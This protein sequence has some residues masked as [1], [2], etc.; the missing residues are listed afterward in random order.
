VHAS[1]GDIAEAARLDLR[2]VVNPGSNMRLGNGAPP[3]AALMEAGIRFGLGTDNCALDDNED[4]LSELRLGRLLGRG[5]TAAAGDQLRSS[6]AVATEWGAEAAFLP[7]IGR[8]R[9]GFKADLVAIDLAGS[10]GAY[11]D[12]QMP[13]FE[14]MLAR[15]TRPRHRYDHGRRPHPASARRIGDGGSREHP[16]RGEPD[17]CRDAARCRNAAAGGGTRRGF[18]P[19]LRRRCRWRDVTG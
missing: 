9:D 3:V 16:R 6:I 8:I 17:R 7:D 13:M 19:P 14:A 5:A 10:E 12:P 1:A 2:I 18:A 4:Y 15:A 11:L